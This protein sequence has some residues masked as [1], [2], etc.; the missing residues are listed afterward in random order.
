MP[1]QEGRTRS[2]LA[3]ATSE[4]RSSFHGPQNVQQHIGHWRANTKGKI[5][6]PSLYQTE[7]QI[8]SNRIM[9][10]SE[11]PFQRTQQEASS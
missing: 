9:K 10:A 1:Q 7:Y 8:E 6:C 3:I 4:T 11:C 2:N 5:R